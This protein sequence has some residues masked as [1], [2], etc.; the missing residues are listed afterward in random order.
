MAGRSC[1]RMRHALLFLATV[2]SAQTLRVPTSQYDNL[3]TGANVHETVL[4][5]GNVNARQFGKITSLPVD[6][7]VYAQPLYL[8]HV[9]VP[10]KGIHNLLFIATEHESVYAFDADSPAATPIW[11]VNLLG[12]NATPL[13]AADVQC[14]FIS[15]ELGITSTPVIDTQTGTLYVLTRAKRRKNF[16]SDV[17]YVQQLHALAITTGKE[18]FGGPAEIHAS[19]S[20]TGEG[21]V[22]GKLSF[23]PLRENPRAA[24]LLADGAVYLTWASSCDVRPYYGWIMAYQPHT[25]R[26]LAVFN[27]APDTGESGIWQSDTGPAADNVGNVYVSTGNGHFDAA[28]A[29]PHNGDGGDYGDSLLKLRLQG[30]RLTLLS[31]FTPYDQ[32]AL[33]STDGDLGSG[34][35]LLIPDKTGKQAIG[36][37]F[38][39]KAGV[40]YQADPNHLPG[41]EGAH[42]SPMVD[43]IAL[44]N[45]IYG[46]PAYWDGNLYYFGSDDPLKAFTIKQGKVATAPS[47]QSSNRS[48]FSGGTPTVSANGTQDGIVWTLETRAWNRGGNAAILN[49]YDARNLAHQLYS[50][51]ENPQRDTPGTALRFTIPTVANGRVYVGTPKSVAVYGLLGPRR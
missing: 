43:R 9:N 17:E 32:D 8:S 28:R 39:G 21:S 6:G 18:K 13:A 5:P 44:A 30:N 7:N 4:T 47:S 15:P 3:R 38:G 16:L 22:A 34:G 46:A 14:P 48:R 20:G 26:Q 41:F 2:L 10:G 49:A 12:P 36:V 23:D 31:Y 42:P 33:N 24:L 45:G 1:S 27:T 40:R 29:R 35:P 25:L 50:S 37:V 51:A 11:Q 19:V